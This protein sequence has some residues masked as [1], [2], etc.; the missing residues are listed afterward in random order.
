MNQKIDVVMTAWP[1]HPSRMAYFRHTLRS[2]QERLSA[3]GYDMRFCCSSE[4][5]RDPAQAW[6]GEELA[7]LCESSGVALVWRDGEAS[8]G[9]N[10]NAAM[11][12]VSAPLFL[13]VQDD[14]ALLRDCDM[15]PG[16]RFM[17]DHPD[18]ALLRYSW[19]D[20]DAMRPTFVDQPDG[21]RRIDLRG[22][23]PYGDDPALRHGDF[24]QRWGWYKEGG[25]HGCSEGDMLHRL[26]RGGADIRVIDGEPAFGHIGTIP[27]VPAPKEHRGRGVFR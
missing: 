1:N 11:R 12:L 17:L 2:L 7:A 27:S 5:E 25:L 23:W 8:L 9:A 3:T 15:G 19:P 18:V 26:V 4:T 10:M 6:C 14:W 22:K 21:W 24:M 13:L 20:C 16:A